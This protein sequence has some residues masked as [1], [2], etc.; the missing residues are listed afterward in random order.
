MLEIND[1]IELE[2]LTM[3]LINKIESWTSMN[4]KMHEKM[5]ENKGKC[6]S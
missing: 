6:I 2:I 5:Q 3:K 1:D 4:E